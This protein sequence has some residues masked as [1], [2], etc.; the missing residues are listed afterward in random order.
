MIPTYYPEAGE[1][2][3]EAFDQAQY[4]PCPCAV[5]FNGISVVV[6]KDMSFPAFEASYREQQAGALKEYRASPAYQELEAKARQALAELEL[7][8][9]A[10]LQELETVST[11]AELVAWVGEFAAIN[12]HIGLRFDRRALASRLEAF[13]FVSDACVGMIKS[14]ITESEELNTRY[15]VGQAIS[16][17]KAGMPMH[18][19]LDSFARAYLARHTQQ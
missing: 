3:R 10:R 8:V 1:T 17:L 15:I 9:D 18:P 19:T 7:L 5:L 12:D 6:T 11:N 2:L 4:R 16:Q 14:E 13:G